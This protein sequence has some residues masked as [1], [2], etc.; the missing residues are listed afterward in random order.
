MTIRVTTA[1]RH[2]LSGLPHLQQLVYLIGIRPH[3]D[4]ENGMVGSYRGISYQSISEALYVQ[5][6]QGYQSGCPSKAQ[7]RRALKGLIKNRV[8]IDQSSVDRLIFYCPLALEDFSAQKKGVIKP[9][10]QGVTA[11]G[12]KRYLKTGGYRRLLP[13]GGTPK[14]AQAVTPPEEKKIKKKQQWARIFVQFPASSSPPLGCCNGHWPTVAKRQNPSG[15]G[16]SD[17]GS[18][19][20]TAHREIL[21]GIGI[22]RT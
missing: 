1:E 12:K 15:R 8:L 19:A 4:F 14:T 18:S 16:Q 6:H 2:A 20:F 13:K 9:S 22:V 5:P 7:I 21:H 17:C 10:H 3:M 11:Q